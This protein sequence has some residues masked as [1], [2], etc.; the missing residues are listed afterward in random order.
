MGG[1]RHC[2]KGV[3]FIVLKQGIDE[4]GK[5]RQLLFTEAR[6]ELIKKFV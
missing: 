6:G 1:F 2:V 5:H 3:S 4:D